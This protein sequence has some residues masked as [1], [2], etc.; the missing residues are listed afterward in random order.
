[1]YDQCSTFTSMS[2]AQRI[3][4]VTWSA[5]VSIYRGFPAFARLDFSAPGKGCGKTV[6]GEVALAFTPEPVSIA[7]STTQ[8]IKGWF[9]E[10]PDST[11]MLDERDGM[12]GTTGRMVGGRA[13]LMAVLLAGYA[14]EGKVMCVRN[15]KSVLM[16]VYNAMIH[17]GIGRAPATLQDRSL[18]INLT[19]QQPD[20]VWI[21]ELYSRDLALTGK[22]V[23]EWLSDKSVRKLLA[24]A[25]RIETLDKTNPRRNL[26]M[27]PMGAV[28]RAAGI[29]DQWREADEEIQSGIIANPLPSRGE[30]LLTS[31]AAY[32][33]KLLTAQD[34]R[35]ANPEQFP[36]GRLGDITIAGLLRS[37]GVES[38][39]RDGTRGY[40]IPDKTDQTDNTQHSGTAQAHA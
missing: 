2:V 31:L 26:I 38:V 28:A 5:A 25:P 20:E 39:V 35:N 8:A 3:H 21:P 13:E 27:A 14:S 12:L 7:Y 6:S 4:V 23:A 1:M 34:V 17:A 10:H 29:Y 22:E 33:G 32:A 9:D 18:T 36:S 37:A 19:K 40:L 15:G 16:Y 24:A 30:M 11:V